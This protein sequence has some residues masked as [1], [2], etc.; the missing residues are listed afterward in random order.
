MHSFIFDFFGALDEI[1]ISMEATALAG[2]L[3]RFTHLRRNK[4]TVQEIKARLEHE[5]RDFLVG[6]SLALPDSVYLNL[7]FAQVASALRAELQQQRITVQQAQQK[8]TQSNIKTVSAAIV[9][10]VL[11]RT[12]HFGYNTHHIHQDALLW[13][14]WLTVFLACP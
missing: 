3:P 2:G 14:S 4:Q 13:Y 7:N 11:S 1:R 8:W 6:H 10:F 12:M 9:C 5:Y